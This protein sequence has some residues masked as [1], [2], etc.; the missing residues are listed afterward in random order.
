MYFKTCSVAQSCPTLCD[1][2]DCNRLGS[3][4]LHYL[5]EFPNSQTKLRKHR[6]SLKQEEGHHTLGVGD[7]VPIQVNYRCWAER[8]RLFL[9]SLPRFSL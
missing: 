8:Q 7:Q 3:P 6:I 5:L 1:S 2:M 9:P 4:F